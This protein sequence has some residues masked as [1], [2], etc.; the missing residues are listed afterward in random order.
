[1]WHHLQ[2]QESSSSPRPTFSPGICSHP[3][4][5]FPPVL[6]PCVCS[7]IINST[8]QRFHLEIQ[9]NNRNFFNFFSHLDHATNLAPHA[10]V[11]IAPPAQQRGKKLETRTR[12]RMSSWEWRKKFCHLPELPSAVPAPPNTSFSAR[13]LQDP[14]ETSPCILTAGTSGKLATF[15]KM[16]PLHLPKPVHTVH[17]SHFVSWQMFAHKVS[18]KH[19][20]ECRPDATEYYAVFYSTV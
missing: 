14:Q 2:C 16:P 5:S 12:V 3:C 6:V 7:H 19:H 1:M 18:E 17:I 10:A 20:S 13:P 9:T 8:G 11:Q 15:E 4:T